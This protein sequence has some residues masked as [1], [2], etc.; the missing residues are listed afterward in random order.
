MLFFGG[1]VFCREI[2]GDG[3]DIVREGLREGLRKCL[4]GE[5]KR[6]E[7][8]GGKE[9]EELH[10][11]HR[12]V[13]IEAFNGRMEQ[14]NS[15]ALVQHRGEG[16]TLIDIFPEHFLYFWKAYRHIRHYLREMK[17]IKTK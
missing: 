9:R 6:G 5:L 17:V 3:F 1:C 16:Y 10:K 13:K 11:T 4:R 8:G 15:S 7:E 14:E 12:K 2:F